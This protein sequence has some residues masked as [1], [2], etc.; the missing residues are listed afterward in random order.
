M[1]E[2]EFNKHEALKATEKRMREKRPDYIAL[3]RYDGMYYSYGE[4]AKEVCFVD[5]VLDYITDTGDYICF[6][7]S[8]LDDVLPKLIKAGRGVLTCDIIEDDPQ[9]EDYPPEP[10]NEN[11]TKN[12]ASLATFDG[13]NVATSSGGLKRRTICD[14]AET[15]ANSLGNCCPML[16]GYLWQKVFPTELF[17][18]I[19]KIS[20]FKPRYFV[21]YTNYHLWKESG[22]E[23]KRNGNT[24]VCR[25]LIR[26]ETE[27]GS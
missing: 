4:S 1:N 20:R 14:H 10:Y 13:N 7:E 5:R 17:N 9:Q 16:P 15:S 27:I 11:K 8:L 22:L 18:A 3:I 26:G 12:I 6:P 19:R 25:T 23:R 21:G 2:K 24:S